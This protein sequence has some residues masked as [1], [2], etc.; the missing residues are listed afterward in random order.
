MRN[1]ER[2]SLLPLVA[3]LCLLCA[4]TVVGALRFH[5]EARREIL[6]R[7]G[8]QL[9]AHASVTAAMV[10][11]WAG[12]QR[13]AVED[14]AR[15]DMLRLLASEIAAADL[16]V[17][18]LRELGE[19]S[20]TGQA[21]NGHSSLDD[22][23]RRVLRDISPHA[24]LIYRKFAEYMAR[25]GAV[26]M[27]LLDRTCE[28]AIVIGQGWQTETRSLLRKRQ[29]Q[30][31]LS[32]ISWLPVRLQGER[33][34]V[35]IAC[36]V[37]APGYMATAGDVPQGILL[38]SC[39]IGALLQGLG[40]APEL[41]YLGLLLERGEGQAQAIGMGERPSLNPIS[42]PE[43]FGQTVR[44][45]ELLLPAFSGTADCLV[46]GQAVPGTPWYAAVAC[47]AEDVRQDQDEIGVR[48][49]GMAGLLFLCLAGLL[50]WSFWWLGVR[51][52]RGEARELRELYETM[53]RQRALLDTVIRAMRSALALVDGEGRLVYAN[54]EFA[55][56]ARCQGEVLPLMQVRHL[57]DYL[58]RSLERHVEFVSR[59]GTEFSDQEDMLVEGRLV[60]FNVQCLPF[61]MEG[62]A[63]GIV[64]IYRDIT[65]HVEAE[66]RLATMLRQTVEAFTHAVEAVD[67]YLQGQSGF[68]AELAYHLSAWLGKD[69]PALESTLRTAASLSHVGMIRLPHALLTKAGPLTAEERLQMEKHVEY[70][71][72]ALR[73]IDFGLPVLQAI[74]QMY[75]RMDGSGYPR[76]LQGEAICLQARIL[77]VADTFCALMRPRA[78]RRRHDEPAALAILRERPFKY[79]Q[80]VVDALAAFLGSSQGK[81]FVR[82][83]RQ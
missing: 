47:R 64:V 38:V 48:I 10:T 12:V 67:P 40:Q 7:T 34:L 17:V 41:G 39:D 70:A 13:D 14:M 72:E 43:D 15:Y 52:E 62:G 33:L 55:R 29:A 78:Y 9:S 69:D 80:Q 36:P 37:T 42:L 3:G 5:E 26:G 83:L 74:E 25:H 8:S 30:K 58:A 2:V 19:T 66:L 56:L 77:A 45:R 61:T 32:G 35:D 82:I 71:V 16:P 49:W 65:A 4:L 31:S 54:T 11:V 79:D 73:G 23:E 28:P 18:L 81:E 76:Q 20:W 53:S 6:E 21:Y 27:A 24:M 1:P 59:T 46:V 63:P 51:R 22:Q 50:T 44:P 68:T 75:E 60:H 57:P